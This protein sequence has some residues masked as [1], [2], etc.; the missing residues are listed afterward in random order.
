MQPSTVKH[1]FN[2]RVR[3]GG[4]NVVTELCKLKNCVRFNYLE[5]HSVDLYIF[6]LL[7]LYF[8]FSA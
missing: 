8:S 6:E 1:I 2:S 4:E 3:I 7:N 5:S